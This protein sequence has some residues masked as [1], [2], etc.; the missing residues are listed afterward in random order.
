MS[1]TVSWETIARELF[2]DCTA[3][4]QRANQVSPSSWVQQSRGSWKGAAGCWWAT[5]IRCRAV[6][7]ATA[8][9]N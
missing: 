4:A 6:L 5:S 9:M 8:P 7:F 2:A 3:S 1:S